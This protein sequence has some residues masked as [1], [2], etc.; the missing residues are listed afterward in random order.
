MWSCGGGRFRAGAQ[1]DVEA[2]G[3]HRQREQLPHGEAITVHLQ[4][5]AQRV[6]RRNEVRIGLANKL[7]EEA[8]GAVACKE[9]ADQSTRALEC[10]PAVGQPQHEA[11]KDHALHEGFIELG[12]VARAISHQLAAILCGLAWEDHAP[13]QIGGATPELCVDEI[14]YPAQ[15]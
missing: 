4:R 9:G 10:A 6:A 11:A 13:W 1:D 12:G 3:D 7:H 2:K 8:R 5:E 15:E 14:G